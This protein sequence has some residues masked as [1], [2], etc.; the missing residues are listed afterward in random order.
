M[1]D[2]VD[3]I[4]EYMLDEFNF[5]KK[6]ELFSKKEIKGIVTQRRTHE[7]QLFRKDAA[8]SYFIDAINYEKQLSKNK[9]IRKLK[10]KGMKKKFDF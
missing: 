1:A 9:T 2:K 4:M 3:Q 5:Y 6:E 7:Y 10:Y 8:V